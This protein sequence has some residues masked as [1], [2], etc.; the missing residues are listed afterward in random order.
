MKKTHFLV[1]LAMALGISVQLN[2][3]TDPG[4][5]NLKHKWTFE[6]GTANDVVGA[7]NGTLFGAATVANGALNLTT[8]TSWVELNGAALN[9]KSYPALTVSAWYKSVA[10]GNTGFHFLYYLG[11]SDGNGK[12]CTGYT[13]ARGNDRSR[14]LI[15]T[16][17][18]EKGVDGSEYDD[19]RLHHI[20][21]VITNNTLTYYIDGVFLRTID[22][23]AGS[24]QSVGTQ[25]AYFGKGG[26]PDPTWRGELYDISMYDAALTADNVKYLY[27]EFKVVVNPVD[28]GI[29]NLTH[30]WT[31]DDGTAT[32]IVGGVTTTLQGA[33]TVS[34]KAL[35]TTAG[36]YASLDGAALNIKGNTE[37]TVETWF[38][39]SKGNNTG[40]HFI[41]YFGNMTNNNGDHF[42]GFSPARG[43]DISRVMFDTGAGSK[44]VVNTEF[45]DGILHHCV[46]V[47][48]A[49]TIYYYL[50]G[51]L[52]N[53]S[54]IGTSTL[55]NLSNNLAYFG[56]G[57]WNADPIWKGLT[58]K[59]SI[60]N[61]ALSLENVKYMYGV[62]P[63]QTPSITTSMGNFA[64][65]S[66]Y[67]A[68]S[69][70]VT[71]LNL[72][73][74]IQITAPAGITVTPST[75]TANTSDVAVNVSYDKSTA[76]DGNIVL[77]SGSVV[78]NIPV[79][80]VVENCYTKLYNDRPNIIV[81]Y[82]CNNTSSFTG[83][84]TREVHNIVT[85]PANVYCG[86]SSIAVG[87]GTNP[88]N[89]GTGSLDFGLAGKINPNSTYRVK[90]MMKT[91]GGAFQIGVAG[92]Q[93]GQGDKVFPIETNG[94][95]QALEFAFST[96]ATLGGGPVIF[97]NNWHTTGLR[98][99]VDNWEMYEV[100]DLATELSK[101]D[102]LLQKVYVVDNQ[103]VA[104]FEAAKVGAATIEV[105]N[106]QGALMTSDVFSCNAGL[107]T[108]QVKAQGAGVYVVRLVVDG[109][110]S[111][112]KIVK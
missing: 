66:N 108:R 55:A 71:S 103:I 42:V 35:N 13:P 101:T 10:G 79:K 109:K 110:A 30:Q 56:K 50:D 31:F 102:K 100:T 39:S 45:D 61:K 24:L 28:P 68:N 72:S 88:N 82:G 32:D 81:D 25:L 44:S 3:Q 2:A 18:T 12:N 74:N 90:A 40:W 105:Y 48:D 60:Y 4:T 67:S 92:W 111:Y 9:V 54:S 91:E 89:N 63:E 112:T 11:E 34:G 41:Y 19:G 93:A 22:I 47:I 85:D 15:L 26:W 65:D 8:A 95:W 83:W 7:V 69:M 1:C 52:I 57:G 64:F 107:N 96:G 27:N 87:D 97:V 53:T 29:T 5:A 98:A 17:G 6:D 59:I 43:E 78:V 14:A 51:I 46:M 33:A 36:G 62:G 73:S 76:V 21:S 106:L 84:G 86:A 49:T 77:T 58:H 20:V 16:G 38:T 104:S 99:Y 94:A 37:L 23:T 75:V 80:A 70:N